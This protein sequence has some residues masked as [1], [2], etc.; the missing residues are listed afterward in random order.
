MT[1]SRRFTPLLYRKTPRAETCGGTMARVLYRFLKTDHTHLVAVPRG[2]AVYDDETLPPGD[3][4]PCPDLPHGAFHHPLGGG[5][6]FCDG[7][8]HAAVERH[9]AGRGPLRSEREDRRPGTELRD[10]PGR[11]AGPGEDDDRFRAQRG[12]GADRAFRHDSRDAVRCAEIRRGAVPF[13]F[14]G[15]EDPPH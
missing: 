5:T 3:E 7:G 13:L 9:T 6:P 11:V 2:R 4:V 14:G 10:D 12:G 8:F 15:G 1:M